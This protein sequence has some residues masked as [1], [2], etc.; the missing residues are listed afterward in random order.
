MGLE[1]YASTP[2]QCTKVPIWRRV[3]AAKGAL[4]WHTH[5]MRLRWLETVSGRQPCLGLSQKLIASI[6][7]WYPMCE[8]VKPSKN[9]PKLKNFSCIHSPL[10]WN[11]CLLLP[12][13]WLYPL[14]LPLRSQNCRVLLRCALP[15]PLGRKTKAI[16]SAWGLRRC[17]TVGNPHIVWHCQHCG[18]DV[19]HSSFDV[20]EAKRLFHGTWH[21]FREIG[22]LFLHIDFESV[23]FQRLIFWIC[24]SLYPAS[25]RAFAPPI[26]REWV[27]TRSMGMP[28]SSGYWSTRAAVLSDCDTSLSLTST[29]PLWNTLKGV[30]TSHCSCVGGCDNTTGRVPSPRPKGPRHS[31]RGECWHVATRFSGCPAWGLRRPLSWWWSPLRC[32]GAAVGDPICPFWKRWRPAFGIGQFV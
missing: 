16:E 30:W 17:C 8:F 20:D 26:L 22:E 27:L 15:S 2:A 3:A 23:T 14:G 11:T 10:W 29:L 32:A 28:F 7:A 6:V 24:I 4:G 5:H 9:E 19:E 12:A 21:A 1:L 13:P 25:T 31:I 18:G